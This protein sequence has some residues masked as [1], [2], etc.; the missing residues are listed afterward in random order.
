MSPNK[1]SLKIAIN[2]KWPKNQ[3][4]SEEDEYKSPT[5]V[6]CREINVV[7]PLVRLGLQTPLKMQGSWSDDDTKTLEVVIKSSRVVQGEPGPSV[8]GSPQ[9]YHR[10]GHCHQ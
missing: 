8:E 5:L 7:V 2:K 1:Y 10:W 9:Y 6:Y 3:S 4:N